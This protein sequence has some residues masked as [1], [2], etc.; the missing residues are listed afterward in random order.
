MSKLYTIVVG[1]AAGLAPAVALASENEHGFTF[2]TQGLFI[3]DFVVLIALLVFLTRKKFATALQ[4]R[5]AGIRKDIDEATTEH[6]EAQ[7]S[8]TEKVGHLEG[9]KADRA[10]L[11]ARFRDEAAR[12][13]DRVLADADARAKRLVSEAER[14][15]EA[16][17]R[18]LADE[19]RGRLIEQTFAAARTEIQ[20]GM[21]EEAR[22]RWTDD[23]VARLAQADGRASHA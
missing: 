23:A 21:T 8:A 9:L 3:I 11:E 1:A 17:R 2:G 5:A 15:V 6:D 12:E 16:E 7:K 20:A 4:D 19:V 22:R 18:R 13:H 10:S 14:Q